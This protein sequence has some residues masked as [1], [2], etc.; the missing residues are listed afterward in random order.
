M[1]NEVN[2]TPIDH[3]QS[4]GVRY[5]FG[6]HEGYEGDCR[7]DNAPE[8]E[9]NGRFERSP[10]FI[11]LGTGCEL[12]EIDEKMMIATVGSGIAVSLYDPQKRYGVFAYGLITQKVCDDFPH[13]K[14]VDVNEAARSVAPI[15][16]A[17]RLL[18]KNGSS[19]NNARVR[20]FGGSNLGDDS[21]NMGT[22]NYIFFKEYLKRKNL[23]IASEDIGG[24]NVRR[25]HFM[26]DTGAV[27]RFVLKRQADYDEV[28]NVERAYLQVQ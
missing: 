14:N 19:L 15:D 17:L 7:R 26:P 27:T 18:E 12:F 3:A 10:V 23:E 25:I 6:A 21:L 22:K 4:E 9:F 5:S 24:S 20:M 11:N 8:S 16:E 2:E 13:L 28:R 1:N